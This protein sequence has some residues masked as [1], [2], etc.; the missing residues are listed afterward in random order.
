MHQGS[1]QVFLDLVELLLG[2]LT[3]GIA[4]LGDFQRI[5]LLRGTSLGP[6]MSR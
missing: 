3:F 2:D 5:V 6:L 1:G 4:F